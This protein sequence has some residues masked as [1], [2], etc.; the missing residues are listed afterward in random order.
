M[1]CIWWQVLIQMDAQIMKGATSF[2]E[3]VIRSKTTF[4]SGK[5]LHLALGDLTLFE[6]DAIVNA[7]DPLL[8]HGGGVAKAIVDKGT[9]N[10]KRIFL[11]NT[12]V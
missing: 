9:H 8:K 2:G 1:L 6:V 5:T 12:E 3:A 10:T 7:A 11:S 4:S